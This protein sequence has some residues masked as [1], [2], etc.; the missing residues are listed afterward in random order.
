MGMTKLQLTANEKALVLS[1]AE[2]GY[3]CGEKGQN[4]EMMLENVLK[5][6]EGKQ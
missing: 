1:A 3:V 6:I 4:K 5:I 2:L